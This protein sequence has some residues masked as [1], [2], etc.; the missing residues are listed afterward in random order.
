[1][2]GLTEGAAKT[3][4]G[5]SGSDF[6]KD[7]TFIGGSA[8]AVQIEH[9]LSEDLDFCTWKVYA[10]DEP[11][12]NSTEIEA[13][14]V[15]FGIKSKNIYGFNQVDYVLENGVKIS[16]Y[17]NQL[18]KSPVTK[19]VNIIGNVFAPFIETLGVMK[20]ELMIRRASFRDYYDIYSILKEGASIGQM[21]YGAC[22]YSN[23]TLKSKDIL[24]FIS[25]GENYSREIGFEKLIPRYQVNE[26]DIEI[27]IKSL[28][29]TEFHKP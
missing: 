9:R 13:D 19:T 26:K 17:A 15:Q 1:L 29:E 12:V 5:L 25:N 4:T 2:K 24:A 7:Y 22:K 21:V 10:H 6:L 14:L 27:F 20:L 8:I 3:L 23:N 28:I 16:F 18:Y 11:T